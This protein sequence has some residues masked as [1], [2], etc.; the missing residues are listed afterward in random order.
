MRLAG[1]AVAGLADAA[2]VRVAALT[3]AAGLSA[4]A[5]PVAVADWSASS[6]LVVPALSAALVRV[7]VV[8]VDDLRRVA[9]RVA[10]A[11]SSAAGLAVLAR[12]VVRR[13]AAAFGACSAAAP[14][15]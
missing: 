7:P 14:A 1:L 10:A 5:A 9:G 3:A 8:L 6:G 12:L 2:V 4:I 11:V 15:G 13:L